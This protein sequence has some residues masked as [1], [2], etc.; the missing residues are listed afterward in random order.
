MITELSFTN[1]KSWK[2]FKKTKLGNLTAFFGTNSS[3]KTSILDFILLLKQTLESSDRSQVLDFGG[4]NSHTQLGSFIDLIFDHDKTQSLDFNI[5][6]SFL[7]N[8]EIY[9]PETRKNVLFSDNK[10][11][12]SSSIKQSAFKINK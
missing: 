4:L 7:K 12:F 11:K 6:L 3:G 9:D 5:A 1:F 8:I 2:H 10:I